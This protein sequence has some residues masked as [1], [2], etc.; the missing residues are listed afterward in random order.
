MTSELTRRWVQRRRTSARGRSWASRSPAGRSAMP[1]AFKPRSR[2]ARAVREKP[3]EPRRT[4]ATLKDG[5]WTIGDSMRWCGHL[6][7]NAAGAAR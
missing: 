1:F 6:P 7:R 3:G 5:S 2:Y 4:N